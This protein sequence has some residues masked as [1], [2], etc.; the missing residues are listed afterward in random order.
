VCLDGEAKSRYDSIP[1][2]CKEDENCGSNC[3]NRSLFIEC[4]PQFCKCGEKCT[5][6]RFQ[7][8]NK[9]SQQL[10]VFWVRKL[11]YIT[12]HLYIYIYIF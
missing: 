2:D 1:C 9:Q 12:N 11:L 7:R 5:N 10:K 4:N 6:Q 8:Y 3:I